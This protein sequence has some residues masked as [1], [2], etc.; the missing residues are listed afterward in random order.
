MLPGV[1]LCL[2]SFQLALMVLELSFFQLY[3]TVLVL[4]TTGQPILSK[5]L[6]QSS[7]TGVYSYII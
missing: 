6:I 4:C 3:C 5:S 1:N 7:M 2:S